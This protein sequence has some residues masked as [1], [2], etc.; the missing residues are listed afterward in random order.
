MSTDNLLGVT[1]S[2]KLLRTLILWLQRYNTG[3]QVDL[4]RFFIAA[5]IWKYGHANEWQL[6]NCLKLYRYNGTIPDFVVEYSKTFWYPLLE[7]PQTI[8]LLPKGAI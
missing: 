2:V 5:Q 1:M 4:D 3:Y 8:L 6:N 7:A